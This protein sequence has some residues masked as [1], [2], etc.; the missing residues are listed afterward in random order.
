MWHVCGRGEVNT[1]FWWRN[2]RERDCFEDLGVDRKILLKWISN[3]L[4]IGGLD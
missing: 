4:G 1:G 2:L 3:R